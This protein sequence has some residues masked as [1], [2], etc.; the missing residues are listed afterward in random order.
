MLYLRVYHTDMENAKTR[1]A[2]L[3]DYDGV[4]AIGQFYDGLD[5]LPSFYK[6]ILTDPDYRSCVREVDGEIV[7]IVHSI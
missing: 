4:M 2:T 1:K 3:E 7:G 6:K 5:Y